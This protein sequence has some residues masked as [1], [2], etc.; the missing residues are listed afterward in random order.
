MILKRI[1]F[2]FVSCLV[3]TVVIEAFCA[4]IIGVR[5]RSDQLTV[6]LSNVITNPLLNSFLTVVSFYISQSLYYWF[7]IP[8]EIVVILVEGLIYR[9]MLSVKINP[10]LLSLILNFC[11]YFI[12]TG[13]IKILF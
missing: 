4:W 10:F 13:I 6:F 12:G 7:L 11:S 3:L 8:L 9:K 1:L 2:K 5:K